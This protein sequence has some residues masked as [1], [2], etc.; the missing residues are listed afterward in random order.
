M[1]VLGVDQITLLGRKGGEDTGWLELKI[2][3]E[4]DPIRAS[5]VFERYQQWEAGLKTAANRI[6]DSS[7]DCLPSPP[8]SDGLHLCSCGKHLLNMGDYT[9]SEEET[10][11]YL[12]QV[13]L[14]P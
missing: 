5:I 12:R 8:V 9:I 6:G 7:P 1:S 3:G 10:E 13:V 11:V 2:E 4:E 14:L